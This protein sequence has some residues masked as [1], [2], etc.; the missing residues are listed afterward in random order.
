MIDRERRLL[1]DE[2]G[3][4]VTEIY[5][6]GR[7]RIT[8]TFTG[9]SRASAL[10]FFSQHRTIFFSVNLF[11]CMVQYLIVQFFLV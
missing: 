6:A 7:N 1:Q 3:S 9:E 5:I 11:K 8:L 2:C 4:A 10:Y